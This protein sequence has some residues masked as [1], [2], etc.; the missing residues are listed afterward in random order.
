MDLCHPIIASKALI[1]A[2]E[3]VGASDASGEPFDPVERA[4][5]SPYYG[6]SGARALEI[7]QADPEWP[8]GNIVYA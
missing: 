4:C 6:V 1:E 2:L 3:T 8:R 5:K 7:I